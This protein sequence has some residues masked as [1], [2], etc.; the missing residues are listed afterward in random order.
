MFQRQLLTY[1]AFKPNRLQY[2]LQLCTLVK[3]L[4]AVVDR[5][6]V[7]NKTSLSSISFLD[8]LSGSKR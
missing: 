7:E 2:I 1:K 3:L 4:M 5:F 8:A 6:P